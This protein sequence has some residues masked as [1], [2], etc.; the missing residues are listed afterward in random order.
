MVNADSLPSDASQRSNRSKAPIDGWEL[1]TQKDNYNV[2]DLCVYFEIDSF[3]PVRPEFEFL[4]KGCFKSTKNL[5]DGFRIKTIKLRGQVSQGLS[6]PMKDFFKYDE[7]KKVWYYEQ[8]VDEVGICYDSIK[9][10]VLEG[11]DVTEYFKVQKYEK[12]EPAGGFA[13][14]QAK[15][16]FPSFLQ[17]TD[18]ERIQNCFGSITNWIKYE[19]SEVTEITDPEHIQMIEDGRI[20]NHSSVTFFKSGD[21]WFRRQMIENDPGIQWQRA[22]FEATLKLDGSS[23][24]V[25]HNENTYGVCSRNL[26]LKRDLENVFWKVALRDNIVQSLMTT[27][28]NV[29]L[30]G[31]LMGPGVQGNR[32][33]LPDHRFFIFDVFLIDEKRYMTS[34]ERYSFIDELYNNGLSDRVEPVPFIDDV[35]F[36]EF[37]DVAD[38]L[39]SAERSSLIHTIA[40]GVVFK[41]M[42]EGGP[43]FKAISNSFLLSEKD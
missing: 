38:V 9:V 22:V 7:T 26:E 43:S 42:V 32:E 1:V 11:A 30:Q 35:N 21:L 23:M 5:G 20:E 37:K 24:T 18:Q 27:G 13:G 3:L 2:G 29:A 33:K 31:E 14:G 28:M 40:E 36:L 6:L 15:G 12:P 16:N 34:V 19:K 4:R 39:K 17:K 25:Y 8:I 41:S 10:P